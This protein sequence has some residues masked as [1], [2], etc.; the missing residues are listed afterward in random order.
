VPDEYSQS[1]A[2]RMDVAATRRDVAATRREQPASADAD[3][4]LLRLPSALAD[5]FSLVA[6][7][8]EQG[9]EADV[10]LVRD[11]QGVDHVAKIYRR[12]FTVDPAVS[13]KLGELGSRHVVRIHEAGM[14]DGRAY[15]LLE[16][17]PGGN[18]EGLFRDADVRA[19]EE[20]VVEVVQQVAA[21]LEHLHAVGIV[22]RDLKPANVLVRSRFPLDLVLTDFGL[23]RSLDVSAA[24][25]TK[26]MTASYAAPEAWSGHTSAAGDWWALGII[27]RELVTGTRVFA[28]VD[29]KV[30]MKHIA[31][32]PIDLDGVTDPRLRLLCRGLL[33]R[34]SDRRWNHRQVQE[35]LA[36]NSPPVADERRAYEGLDGRLPLW[37]KREPY[38]DRVALARALVADWETAARR[39]FA[40]MGTPQ[41]PSEGWQSLRDWLL[42]F[43]DPEQDDLEGRRELTDTFLTG[44]LPPDR[45]L[46]H[47]LHWLDPG[48]APH[49]LG[50]RLLPEDL[51]TVTLLAVADGGE[52]ARLARR[53]V[54]DLGD[55]EL[56]RLLAQFQ[57][58]EGLLQV[59]QRWHANLR[60]WSTLEAWAGPLPEPVRAGLARLPVRPRLLA[61]AAAPEQESEAL[62]ELAEAAAGEVGDP[63]VWF[64]ELRQRVAGD[65]VGH[66]AVSAAAGFAIADARRLEQARG[67][68]AASERR[69][70]SGQQQAAIWAVAGSVLLLVPWFLL[71]QMRPGG[72]A[73]GLTF[74][75]LAGQVAGEL[76][77][78]WRLAGDYHPRFSLAGEALRRAGPLGRTLGSGLGAAVRPF[79]DRPMVGCLTFGCL[80]LIAVPLLG[81]LLVRLAGIGIAVFLLAAA[82]HGLW[83][84]RRSQRWEAEHEQHRQA[85]QGAA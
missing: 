79:Q 73:G 6:E 72:L 32:R 9:A 8:A 70:R 76:W 82:G 44:G 51:P 59:E 35:W 48:A 33:T 18:L 14:S 26:A 46:L 27:V 12:G 47:L 77:L 49:H 5:R 63:P 36:G 71:R 20:E 67:V 25:L 58:G 55:H 2:T 24:Y 31:T 68:W 45:K 39:F 61:L 13:R 60:R 21:A 34:D 52:D 53:I 40:S 1:D 28:A 85:I 75:V 10:V 23:S 78:A 54:E 19:S 41:D 16:Y 7:L 30:V 83:T 37:F 4:I 65:P 84:W 17:V 38:G 15:E 22:H 50:I 66:L 56:V 74:L 43:D 69:R 80:T 42:Q 62:R 11:R 3:R 81:G 57:G 29:E 64:R